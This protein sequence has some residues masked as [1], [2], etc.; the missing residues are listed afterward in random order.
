MP[1]PL[2]LSGPCEVCGLQTNGRHFGVM[3]CRACASFFRRAENW[4]KDKKPCEKDGNCHILINGKYP[5]KPCRLQKCYEVGMDSN[6]FQTNRDLISSSMKKVPESLATFLGRPAFILCCEPAKI[7][8]NK[9]FIDMTYLVDAAAKMFQR[10]PSHNFRPFQYQNSLEKLAL[11]LDDMR[12]KAPDERMLKIRKMG[13][14]ES[15][16][17]WEQSFLRAVEWLA[18][19]P[20]YNELENYIKLEIVKAA[21]IGWTR[22][23]KLAE[24]A[25]YQRKLVLADNV[26]ML[27]DDT[28]LDFGNFEFDLTWCTN[29]TME[30]LEFYI[31][32]QLEQYCQQCVQDLVELAPTNIELNYMLLQISLY[33]AGNKC[34]GKVLEACEKLMQTQADHLHEYYVNKMK[35]PY[36]SGRLAK[37][38][39]INKGIEADMRGRAERNQLATLFNV[40]KIEFSHPD[41]FDAN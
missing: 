18:S 15:I 9:T 32:P 37:M 1:A 12:L 10:Q 41:M 34:Q 28:C 3:S 29:Y 39:R 5:C 22:L 33:H 14:A 24:T 21:W 6:R 7:A 11:T 40:L 20:E 31:S 17:I 25:D 13:K 23:E 2:F 16:F 36:Y 26:Y 27:G 8:V 19:F 30:Q 4:K 38:L 35:Q